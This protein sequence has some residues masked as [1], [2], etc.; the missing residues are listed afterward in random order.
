MLLSLQLWLSDDGVAVPVVHNLVAV[1]VAVA[2]SVV[3]QFLLHKLLLLPLLLFAVVGVAAPVVIN[4]LA[5]FVSNVADIAGATDVVLAGVVVA[6]AV[7]VC[8]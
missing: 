4:I 2:V 8:P 3:L 5:V 6:V 1:A 7:V